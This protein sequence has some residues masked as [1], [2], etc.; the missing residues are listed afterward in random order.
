MTGQAGVGGIRAGDRVIV[1]GR[2]RVVLGASGTTMR[3]AGDDGAV[4]EAPIAEMVGSGRLRLQPRGTGGH[5]GAQI[6]LAGLAGGG[7]AGAV[8]G[9]PH[10]RGRGRDPP[11]CACRDT[12]ASGL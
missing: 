12:L 4:E 8:V 11:G 9:G 6:G 5:R 1:D 2:P 3:F 7:R 10:H